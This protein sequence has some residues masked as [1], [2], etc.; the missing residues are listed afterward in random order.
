MKKPVAVAVLLG[1]LLLGILLLRGEGSS[2]ASR[3]EAQNPDAV[4]STGVPAGADTAAASPPMSDRMRSRM[5]D[6]MPDPAN[7]EAAKAARIAQLE[8]KFASEPVSAQWAAENTQRI[9]SFLAE[10]SLRAAQLPSVDLSA[11]D[12]RTTICRIEL[13]TQ[14]GLAAGELTQGILQ[15]V[16]GQMS[17]AQI[18]ESEGPGG[19]T[20]LIF[21]SV[22]PA[23]EGAPFRT[24][25]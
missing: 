19:T 20:L 4:E 3:V 18:F 9:Q 11:V 21:S 15:T 7:V 16:A 8:D 6:R 22:A 5:P 23:S 17:A 1:G 12:C 25:R 10:D 24:G 2:P 13:R 14:D